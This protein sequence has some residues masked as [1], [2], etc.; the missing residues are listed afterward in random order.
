MTETLKITSERV[1]DIP[2]L[3]AHMERMGLQ[4]LLDEYFPTHGN[5]Q[6]LSLGQVTIVWLAHILSQA[7]HRLNHVQPWAEW[8]QETIKGC[9]RQ[10]MRV[11]DFS[12]DRL[13]DILGI[14]SNDEKW[15]AFESALGQRLL[16]VY[17]LGSKTMRLDSSTFSGYWNVSADGLFQRGHSKD[18]RPD[19][20]QLKVMVA[21]IDPLGMPVVTDVISGNRADDPLYIPAITRVRA[22]L[23]KRGLLYVGD[24]KMAASGTRAFIQSGGDFYLCPLPQVQLPPEELEQYL[25]PVWAKEQELHTIQRKKVGGEEESIAE[26]FELTVAVNGTVEGEQTTWAE[27]RLVIRS[28]NKAKRASKALQERLTKAKDNLAALNER[29]R[30]KKHFRDVESL[31]EATEKIVKRYRVEGLMRLQYREE[32]QQRQV[33]RYRDRPARVETTR[34]VFVE[35]EVDEEAVEEAKRRLGWR[36]YATNSP[37]TLLPLDRAVLAYRDE[38]IV[39]RAFGRLKGR[40]LSLTP[41]YLQQDDHATGLVRLFSIA[42]RVMTLLEF[43]VR[44]SLAKTGEELTGLYAGNPKRAT[45]RPT[46]ERL[47]EAFQQITLTIIREPHQIRRH[48]TPLSKLQLRVLELLGF[49]P[50]IYTR[51]CANSPV[52]P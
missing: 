19:L 22:G 21:T 47:L 23:G 24:C 15:A 29:R 40:P 44:R 45:A 33:R 14:L 20:P 25:R 11:L 52:P 26:G 35:V 18:K 30:G 6:G 32:V 5:W 28:F 4:S 1:D 39:E 31:Q 16:R 43:V 2:L 27:R 46:A 7:D 51:L 41:M 42:L 50:E 48:I 12:D 13:A 49:S 17:D 3:L 10:E 8:R 38:Y 34:E 36:V 9:L 37:A